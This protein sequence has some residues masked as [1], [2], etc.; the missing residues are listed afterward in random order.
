MTKNGS[1]KNNLTK[2]T[3]VRISVTIPASVKGKLEEIVTREK[4]RGVSQASARLIL[5]GVERYDL[6]GQE[7]LPLQP[8]R[9][10]K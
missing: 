10:Q 6:S 8:G 3:T 9:R 2:P 5:E 1:I 7:A 4:L